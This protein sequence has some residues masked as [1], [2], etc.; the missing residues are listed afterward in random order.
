MKYNAP[1]GS[2]DPNAGFVDRSTPNAQ[3]GSKVPAKAIEHPQREIVY[4]L[5]QAGLTPT[6]ATT[7]LWEALQ[8]IMD[9]FRDQLPI[10][11]QVNTSD[12]KFGVTAPSTG[13]IRVPA[14]VE[15]LIR[16][17]RRFVTAQTDRTTTASKTYH[18]RWDKTNGFRLRDLADTGYNPGVL[19]ETNAG[20]DSTYDD[21][22][23]ARVVTN[24]ANV[25]TITNLVN[26]STLTRSAM[27]TGTSIQLASANGTNYLIN[28]TLDW[29]RTATTHALSIARVVVDDGAVDHEQ[30]ILAPG[31]SRTDPGL[32]TSAA[33]AIPVT[34]YGLAAIAVRDYSTELSM[35]FDARA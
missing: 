30:N 31:P 19:A 3:A 12:G 4:V 25:A 17:G 13:T 14:G 5:Q 23:I 8:A 6:D 2:L 9:G 28:D 15:Y 11:P 10:F 18:L 20:F 27:I 35:Q 33:P 26:R 29:A 16:G 1:F 7:Q 21:M 34:R 22:L 24:G 32:M